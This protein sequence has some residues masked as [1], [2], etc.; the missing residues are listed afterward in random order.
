MFWFSS[1]FSS[2]ISTN[3]ARIFLKLIDK[4]FTFSHNI[5]ATPSKSV[6]NVRKISPKFMTIKRKASENNKKKQKQQLFNCKIKKNFL[7]MV[8]S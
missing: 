4:H 8:V 2:N 6:T 3:K 7:S 5:D 1:L